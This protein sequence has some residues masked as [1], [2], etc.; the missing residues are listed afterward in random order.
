[1]SSFLDS[2]SGARLFTC[3]SQVEILLSIALIRHK[4]DAIDGRNAIPY[5]ASASPRLD[6]HS[7]RRSEDGLPIFFDVRWEPVGLAA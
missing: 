1:M 7:R 2:F 3:K 4:V 5:K 6:I